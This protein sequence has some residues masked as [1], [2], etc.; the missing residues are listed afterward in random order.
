MDVNLIQDY[1]W[2]GNDNKNIHFINFA[3]ISKRIWLRIAKTNNLA[4]WIFS[5]GTKKNKRVRY[6]ISVGEF[7]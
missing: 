7:S 1:Y 2:I 3:M 5:T 6:T 4:I